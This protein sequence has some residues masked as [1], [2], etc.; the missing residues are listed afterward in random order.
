MIPRV[1][2]LD[3][4]DPS[5]ALKLLALP[6]LF[7]A[8]V[9]GATVGSFLNVVVYRLP[10]G[11]SLV[12]PASRCPICGHGLSWHENLP[13]VGWLWLGGRCRHCRCPISV[14]YPLVELTCALLFAALAYSLW[15]AHDL[16][17]RGDWFD[18]TVTW[19]PAL[20]LF[21][22]LAG[23]IAATRID[24]VLFI[25][26]LSIPYLVALVGLVSAVVGVVQHPYNRLLVPQAEGAAMGVALGGAVGL[27]IAMGL[28]TVGWMPRSFALTEAQQAEERRRIEAWEAAQ[29]EAAARREAD[30]EGWIA[31]WRDRPVLTSGDVW[32]LALAAGLVL[33]GMGFDAWVGSANGVGVG[34][35][36]FAGWG[37]A[38]AVLVVWWFGL[39]QPFSGDAAS[40]GDDPGESPGGGAGDGPGESSGESPG[41]NP[42]DVPAAAAD[43]TADDLPWLV[44]PHPRREVLKEVLFLV[45]PVCGA[46]LGGLWMA[47]DSAGGGGWGVAGL[48][49]DAGGLGAGVPGGRGGSVVRSDRGDAG[50]WQGGDGAGGRTPDGG[51]RRGAGALGGGAGVAAG[52]VRGAGG[53]GGVCVDRGHSWRG[54]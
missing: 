44:H 38:G 46:V 6:W 8:G 26:P 30:A 41:E 49:F 9:Y 52:G 17:P 19:A 43:D 48:A 3:A 50:V 24:A 5:I 29:A 34:L 25:I 45:L 27:L 40:E 28:W 37:A 20:A 18:M 13:V 4:L 42:G 51:D 22:L 31:R 12:T 47:G 7:A 36:R 11:E 23:L 39:L 35:G 33:L 32:T 53:C 54:G 21:T 15:F 16:Q 1:A 14:R 10:A 2:V